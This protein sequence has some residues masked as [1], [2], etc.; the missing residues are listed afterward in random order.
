MLTK[1]EFVGCPTPLHQWDVADTNTF[2]TWVVKRGVLFISRVALS[3]WD[4][5]GQGLI[6]SCL[7]RVIGEPL[8]YA[9]FR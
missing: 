8:Q 1:D 7:T 6:V 2:F 3:P 5:H 9:L 4:A